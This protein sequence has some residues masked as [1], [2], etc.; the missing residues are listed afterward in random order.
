MAVLA[1]DLGT[2]TGWA[3]LDDQGNRVDSGVLKLAGRR[4]E[5][6]GMR[7]VRFRAS[8]REL[9]TIAE[10]AVVA[11]EEVRRHMGTDAAHVYGGL[12]ATL[13]AELEE[14]SVPYLGLPVST[15]KKL[16]T[17]KGNAGKDMMIEAAQRRWK[18]EP[19]DDNEADALWVAAAAQVEVR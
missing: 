15:V 18:H 4:H 7:Y 11:Y 19:V 6:G 17:G 10:P 2:T 13:Q 16:A 3:V 12:L 1:F 5:G 14:R 9:L 8:L